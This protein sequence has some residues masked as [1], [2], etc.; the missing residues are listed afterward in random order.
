MAQIS[1]ITDYTNG[2]IIDAD[3]HNE[4]HNLFVNKSNE[5]DSRITSLENGNMTISGDKT[6]LGAIAL[7]ST[8]T[9][10]GISTFSENITLEKDFSVTGA[11]TLTG[12]V[13]LGQLTPTL[14]A[15]AASKQYVDTKFGAGL[16]N[17]NATSVP[18]Y[19][20]GT[21]LTV[22]QI[23]CRNSTNVD[24]I[25]KTTAT[26]VDIS[27]FGLNGIAQSGISQLLGTVSVTASTTNVTGSNTSFI[28]DFQ[29][30]D[31]IYVTG[32]EAR[33][34]VSI[35]SNTSMTVE[36]NWVTTASN[37]AY[38]RG[39]RAPNTFYN[40]YAI[41][42]TVS[43]TGLILSTRNLSAGDSLVD[44]PGSI[45]TVTSV[46]ETANTVKTTSNHNLRNGLPFQFHDAGSGS[47]PSGLAF[48]ITYYASVVSTTDFK[49]YTTQSD[50]IA[51]TNEIDFTG[52]KSGT[53]TIV[54]Q[55][56]TNVRQ[57]SFA[58][59]TDLGTTAPVITPFY[60][61]YGWP[62]RP[63]IYY[64]TNYDESTFSNTTTGI[65][66]AGT[67]SA[68]T[69]VD[70]STANWIPP[71]SRL[72]SFWIFTNSSAMRVW[73]KAKGSPSTS[74][75]PTLLG[76]SSQEK[77]VETDSNRTIQFA[78]ASGSNNTNIAVRGFVAT[79]VN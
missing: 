77:L 52:S 64:V 59:K 21:Q 56:Y 24:T 65:L 4:E 12:A 34:I 19:A 53:V 11:S 3:I 7:S 61:A 20:N 35:A 2:S 63:L 22:A 47:L 54:Y 66:T 6:Y 31:V 40:L 48:N 32:S 41:S 8:L 55:S 42:D 58:L 68:N 37:S 73:L 30:G 67:T 18:V 36:S 39:G 17:F 60:V 26:T 57:L 62:S 38:S 13:T 10:S 14:G 43:N 27:T 5:L 50:A 25:S 33:R 29:V 79:E 45:N 76:T 71:I 75:L 1:R 15:H 70:L 72:G 28:T 78:N 9:V 23:S 69:F 74:G 16:L 51:E 49:A 44:L 46:D